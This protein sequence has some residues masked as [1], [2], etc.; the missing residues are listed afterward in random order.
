MHAIVPHMKAGHV[1]FQLMYGRLICSK[2]LQSVFM[3]LQHAKPDPDQCTSLGLRII[4]SIS[5]VRIFLSFFTW[6]IKYAQNHL[7]WILR[8]S[9]CMFD[10]S[11]KKLRKILTYEIDEIILSPSEVH[12]SGSASACCKSITTGQMDL[13]VGVHE[14][15]IFPKSPACHRALNSLRNRSSLFSQWA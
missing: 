12:W 7:K 6:K 4:S 5:Y 2:G 14:F 13:K 3:D 9:K 8:T 1:S 11:R 15:L 10:F